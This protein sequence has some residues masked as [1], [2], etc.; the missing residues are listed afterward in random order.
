MDELHVTSYGADYVSLG[1]TAAEGSTAD[2]YQVRCRSDVN[3][4]SDVAA[5]TVQPNITL[6]SLQPRTTY[7]FAVCQPL[8]CLRLD[9][10]NYG[11][12]M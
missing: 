7:W 3:G 4:V 11:R 5:F 6:R 8:W 2:L 9:Y 10:C 12:P 1:W